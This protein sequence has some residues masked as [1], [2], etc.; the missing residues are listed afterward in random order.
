MGDAWPDG[1]TLLAARPPTPGG[2]RN[3]PPMQIWMQNYANQCKWM[4]FACRY[5]L[6]SYMHV[7]PKRNGPRNQGQRVLC[8]RCRMM[9]RQSSCPVE[10]DLLFGF[11]YGIVGTRHSHIRS[12]R[13]FQ[14]RLDTLGNCPAS[15]ELALALAQEYPG[16]ND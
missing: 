16:R 4:S 13:L 2:T 8:M 7:K 9:R 14:F 1:I 15:P 5:K 6:A 11:D 3:M 10:I 12:F